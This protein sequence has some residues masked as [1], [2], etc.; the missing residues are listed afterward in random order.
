MNNIDVPIQSV[1]DTAISIVEKLKNKYSDDEFL[2]NFKYTN[3][4]TLPK[5]LE[6]ICK[7]NVEYNSVVKYI[8]GFDK[9]DKIYKTLKACFYG[10]CWKEIVLIL[11]V[12]ICKDLEKF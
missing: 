8:D 12:Y 11:T 3:L 2:E 10:T 1:N 7:D 5:K 4:E 6:E 9:D